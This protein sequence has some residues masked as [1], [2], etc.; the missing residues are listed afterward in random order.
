MTALA[1]TWRRDLATALWVALGSALLAPLVGLLLTALALDMA[2]AGDGAGY[3]RV[4]S[5]KAPLPL[6]QVRAQR[7]T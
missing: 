5:A 2:A 7:P 4:R 1:A 6:P 3:R